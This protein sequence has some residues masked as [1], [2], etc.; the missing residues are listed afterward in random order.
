MRGTSLWPPF[1]QLRCHLILTNNMKPT[2]PGLILNS[3]QNTFRISMPHEMKWDRCVWQ[4]SAHWKRSNCA[5]K[6]EKKKK[7][8]YYVMD[9]SSIVI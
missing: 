2:L 9:W 6:K 7:K 4:F 1:A 8:N 5:S 3:A